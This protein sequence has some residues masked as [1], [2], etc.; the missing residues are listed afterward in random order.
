MKRSSSPPSGLAAS[1]RRRVEVKASHR[2]HRSGTGEDAG[3]MD[4]DRRGLKDF[5]KDDSKDSKQE[6]QV[7]GDYLARLKLDT[8]ELH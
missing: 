1:Q 4:S 6:R 8:E 3:H 2:G 7:T 5:R